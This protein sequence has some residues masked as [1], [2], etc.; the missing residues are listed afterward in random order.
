MEDPCTVFDP[1]YLLLGCS[2]CFVVFG[3]LQLVA[4]SCYVG[5]LNKSFL[6]HK[7]KIWKKTIS[8]WGVRF[9]EFSSV[10]NL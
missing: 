1:C 8:S 5:L 6:I 3:Y 7:K 4:A 2:S 10:P 9:D